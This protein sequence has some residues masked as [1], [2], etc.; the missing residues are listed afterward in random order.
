MSAPPLDAALNLHRAGRFD[1]AEQAYRALLPAQPVGAGRLLG[2]LM[3]QLE[4]YAEAAAVL[5]PLMRAAPRDAELAVN[6]SLAL[7][8]S[9]RIEP[10]LAAAR[11]A[12]AADPQRLSAWNAL[13]LAAMEAD[14][15]DEAHAAFDRGLKL[16][17]GHP[18]L[19]LHRAQ[20]LRRLGRLHEAGQA[21][22]A[23]VQAEPTQLEAWRGLAAVNAAVGSTDLALECRRRAVALRPSDPELRLE[24]AIA[25]LLDGWASEAVADLEALLAERSEDARAW[26]WLG[27]AH[28][29]LGQTDRAREAFDAA[30]ARDP[31]DPVVAHFRA[32]LS[33]ELPTG[34]ESDYI[35]RL[36]DDFAGH[37]ESTL[38]GK[39]GYAMPARLADFVRANAG[40]DFGSVLDLGCGTGLMAAELV[41]EGR[42]IDGV[43]L[44]ARMLDAARAKG[45]YRNV[46][47]AEV[48]E[49]L[50]GVDRRWEV[51]V[52]A[53]VFVY[54]A[55]L[56]PVFAAA[57]ERLTEGGAFAFSIEL[58]EGDATEL[59][60][61][62]G[63]Y[64]HV[65]SM[66]RAQLAACG[67][68]DVAE[69]RVDIRLEKGTPVA[70]MLMLAKRP[71]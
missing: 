3:L 55:D 29:K 8:R 65:P 33:G 47:A 15:L 48:L 10:A 34:V 49:F 26:A 39:L 69:R 45:V 61:V 7:R 67:F 37:F 27:R 19:R 68:V 71:G 41:A 24:L 23:L 9:G 20:C 44:S 25:L 66:L 50:R 4:R 17:P 5:A 63:R 6:A 56:A 40:D 14:A 53:D 62:T 51:V 13:G 60:A 18:A 43:D 59:P 12:T 54:I 30:H 1:E 16:S 11:S 64:R 22:H 52:A 31:D 32:A 38:V 28:L 70:G 36:F 46:Y 57:F 42:S 58:S 21:F 35:R 2:V